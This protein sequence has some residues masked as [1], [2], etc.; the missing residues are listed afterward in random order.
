MRG[1][2]DRIAGV[3]ADILIGVGRQSQRP[4]KPCVA[5]IAHHA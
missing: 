3:C 4:L 5:Q 1:G 2:E